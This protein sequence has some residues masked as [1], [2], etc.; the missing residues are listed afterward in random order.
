MI[1]HEIDKL[2]LRQAIALAEENVR[3]KKGGPFA[4]II[5][6]DNQIIAT[7]TNLVTSN[8]DP[9][10]HA[11]VTAIRNACSRLGTFQL[12]GCTVYASCDL[13]P[14][15]W[16]LFI[17]QGRAGWFLPRTNIRLPQ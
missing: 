10:A 11:E 14:C 2:Y 7:G 12:Q 1:Q 3:Q 6:K 17:G 4:A 8:I 9:T 15:A 5:V 16:G 13:V